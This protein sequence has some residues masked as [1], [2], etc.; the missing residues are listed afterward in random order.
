ME[1]LPLNLFTITRD[2]VKLLKKD[3][4]VNENSINIQD[5]GIDPVPAESILSSYLNPRPLAI[6]SQRTHGN[7]STSEERIAEIEKLGKK[8]K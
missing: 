3:N 7:N 1:K 8:S 6:S 5:L 2:Q 4:I